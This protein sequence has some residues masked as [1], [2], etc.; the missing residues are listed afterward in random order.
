MPPIDWYY[1]REN[2][3]MGPVSSA[4]LKRLAA[5]GELQPDDLVWREGLTEWAPARSVRSLFDVETNPAEVQSQ[6]QEKPPSQPVVPLEKDTETKESVAPVLKTSTPR[7]KH[8]V[9]LLLNSL[10]SDFNARF[11]DATA[12]LFRACGLYGLWIGMAAVAVFAVIAAINGDA[13]GNLL[14]GAMVILLLV[15]L[16][17]IAGKFCD[18][19]DRLN[20]TTGGVLASTTLPDS[21]ALLSLV[22]GL[23]ILFGSVPLAVQALMYPM[24]LLGIAGFIICGFIAFAALNP[25]TLN[26][27]I[28]PDEPR[29]SDEAIGVL[30]FLAKTLI[31]SVPVALGTG[32][33]AGTLMMAYACYQTFSHPDN[34]FPAQFTAAASR[35]ILITSAALPLAMYLLFLLYSLLLDLCRGVL[36]LPDKADRLEDQNNDSRL[37]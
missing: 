19:L 11:V 14:S 16:Q 12:R 15:A 27:T 17:Y 28:A 7:P 23:A 35:T 33:I 31:R 26:I 1:A 8:P 34:L 25:S 4:E 10:R 5:D 36:T 24:I 21:V 13:L 32:V 9:D 29:A 37:L 22:A 20:R 18:S 3:Q 6:S 2:K 30:T